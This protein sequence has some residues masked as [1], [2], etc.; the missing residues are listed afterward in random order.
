M[1]NKNF[2]IDESEAGVRIDNY[3]SDILENVSRTKIQTLIKSNKILVNN[4]S[5]KPSYNVNTDDVISCDLEELVAVKIK[6]ENIELEIVYENENFAI[7]NKPSGMLTHPTSTEKSGTL[8][9]ALLAKYGENLSD[10]NGEYRRGILHRLDRNTSGLLIIAKNN[11]AHTKL[12][13]MIKNREIE[14][15]YL[16][17]VR[18]VLKE[19]LVINEPIARN[20]SQPNKMTVAPDGKPSLT[21][22]DI[23]ERFDDATY[24]DV[25]LKTGRTH[26]IRVHLSHIGHP[27]FNDTM[28]GFG[29]VKIKTEEQVLQSY[30]LKFINPFDNQLIDIQIEPDEKLTKVLQYLRAKSL[31]KK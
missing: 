7:V 6:P 10:I 21:E 12:A 31:N 20:K 27:V 18:G 5:C 4:K 24:V 26:Q 14:K 28:Y 19:N 1:T 30:K 13:D 3:L 8:V 29:K 25:N 2:I 9:N 16:T 23:I 15:R 11:D 17:V 22:V